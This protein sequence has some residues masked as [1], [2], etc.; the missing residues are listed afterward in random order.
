VCE[1]EERNLNPANQARSTLN[2]RTAIAWQGG[3]HARCHLTQEEGWPMRYAHRK[4]LPPLSRTPQVVVKQ[5]DVA[6]DR[7]SWIASSLPNPI[8]AHSPVQLPSSPLRSPQWRGRIITKG[9]RV[10]TAFDLMSLCE[11]I[12]VSLRLTPPNGALEITA[13]HPHPPAI[14]YNQ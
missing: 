1:G 10:G 5:H 6:T 13:A 3:R 4:R 8:N 2:K 7:Q 9:I 11:R 14:P 12:F